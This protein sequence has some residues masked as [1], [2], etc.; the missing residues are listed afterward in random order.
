MLAACQGRT[1]VDLLK[2]L[3]IW[4]LLSTN[5]L[6]DQ[7]CLFQVCLIR[8]R[9]SMRLSCG[10][11]MLSLII[12]KPS[13]KLKTSLR[14]KRLRALQIDYER[15]NHQTSDMLKILPKRI[16]FFIYFGQV[17]KW[18]QS[19]ECVLSLKFFD[20]AIWVMNIFCLI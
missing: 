14:I 18:D 11:H 3:D 7:M 13:Q 16:Y 12:Q 20:F 6:P 5:L 19:F 2:L 10:H 9:A 4:N 15:Q 8:M 1:N 17:T